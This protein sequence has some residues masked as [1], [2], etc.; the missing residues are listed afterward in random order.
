[1]RSYVVLAIAVLSLLFCGCR[2][3]DALDLTC[4]FDAECPDGLI[5]YTDR[6][7]CGSN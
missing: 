4:R 5:S 3:T 2:G 6:G 7:L 1:M